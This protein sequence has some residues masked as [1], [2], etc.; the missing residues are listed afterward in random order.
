MPTTEAAADDRAVEHRDHRDG[1]ELDARERFVPHP[2]VQYALGGGPLAELGQIEPGAEML[3]GAVQHD[4]AQALGRRGKKV[5]QAFDGGVV[6][7][8]ALGDAVEAE[9]ADCALAL[10]MKRCGAGF[11]CRTSLRRIVVMVIHYNQ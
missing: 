9:D 5:A 7:R 11:H 6:E 2:G 3:A 10:E 4:G 8:I 1:A